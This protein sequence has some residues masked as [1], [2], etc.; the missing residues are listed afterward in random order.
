M[1]LP[2]ATVRFFDRYAAYFTAS[3]SLQVAAMYAFP[4]S[5]F[6]ATGQSV[7]M[8]RPAFLRDC[9]LTFRKYDAVGVKRITHRLVGDSPIN[10]VIR[11][12]EMEWIFLDQA[13]E[14][15]TDFRTR[16]IVR[17]FNGHLIILGVVE[18]DETERLEQLLDTEA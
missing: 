9:E 4:A 8:D 14:R 12:V 11:L 3:D 2:P 10:G 16:Y 17:D 18:V 1:P 6:S 15:L 5:I 7:I 13:G